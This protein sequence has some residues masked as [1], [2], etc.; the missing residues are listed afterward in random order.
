MN[1]TTLGPPRN[2]SMT[3]QHI[4]CVRMYGSA[5][6]TSSRRLG[7]AMKSDIQTLRYFEFP[8]LAGRLHFHCDRLHANLSTSACGDRWTIAG[9]ASTDVRWVTCKNCRVG[10]L[11][12]GELD[13]NPSP[14]RGVK[15]CARCHQTATRLIGKHLCASC[16]N[17]QREQIVGMNA[18]GT[19]PIKLA[20][21]HGRVISYMANGV[22]KTK[23]V[24]RS[25]DATELI[26]AVLRDE[27]HAVR[28]VWQAPASMR[29][30]LQREESHE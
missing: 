30:L 16:Y 6:R 22:L 3:V 17:R 13:A 25:V 28:F 12:A 27:E 4:T 14:F 20:P 23:T 21:L 15:L 29:T 9:T 2:I 11:H 1:P 26:V 5:T 7:Q 18:K 19:A 10:A 8:E 24:E